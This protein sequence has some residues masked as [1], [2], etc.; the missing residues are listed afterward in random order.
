MVNMDY[1]WGRM[2]DLY[3]NNRYVGFI[4]L[5]LI[6]YNLVLFEFVIIGIYYFGNF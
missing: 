2:C 4:Y 6:L 5:F 3:L 1:F